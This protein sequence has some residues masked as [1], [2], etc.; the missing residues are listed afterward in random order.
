MPPSTT[1]TTSEGYH[2]DEQSGV[3]TGLPCRGVIVP[4]SSEAKPG[5]HLDVVVIGAGYAGL[6]T[7]RE[8]SW[9]GIGDMSV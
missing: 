3:T 1:T 9:K 6:I 4:S 5:T 2:F 8:L 7:A